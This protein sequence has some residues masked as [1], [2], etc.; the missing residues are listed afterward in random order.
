MKGSVKAMSADSE[1]TSAY[2]REFA[3]TMKFL[4]KALVSF[5]LPEVFDVKIIS[6]STFSSGVSRNS[7]IFLMHPDN[8]S[9]SL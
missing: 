3:N 4:S 9:Y 8:F 5:S 7:S 6:R 1:R 2:L